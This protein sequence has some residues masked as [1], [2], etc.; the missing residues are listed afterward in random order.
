VIFGFLGV[1]T[2]IAYALPATFDMVFQSTCLK[3]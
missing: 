3:K 1:T 2:F